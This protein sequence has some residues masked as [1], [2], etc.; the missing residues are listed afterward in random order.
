M[1][2]E[3]EIPVVMEMNLN[4]N[5]LFE[6]FD[7]IFDI[8]KKFKDPVIKNLIKCEGYWIVDSNFEFV[9]KI[10]NGHIINIKEG[11]SRITFNNDRL[12]GGDLIPIT[13]QIYGT[14]FVLMIP[15][16]ISA[17]ELYNIVATWMGQEPNR[18][19]III[20]RVGPDYVDGMGHIL[21]STDFI[22]NG[23]YNFNLFKAEVSKK[24]SD[25]PNHKLSIKE[26]V[27]IIFKL[28]HE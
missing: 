9:I 1:L 17:V 27:D 2:K 7:V 24:R 11:F 4:G 18:I 13:I 22:W 14:D 15:P 5:E 25:M 3:R 23:I 16:N 6:V 26:N 19:R 28:Q 20:S 12:K 8:P 10:G 21:T